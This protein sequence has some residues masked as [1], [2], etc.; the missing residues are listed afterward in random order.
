MNS[1]VFGETMENVRHDSDIKLVTTEKKKQFGIRTKLSYY[2]VFQRKF[3]GYK[4]EKNS[5]THENTHE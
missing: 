2:K 4:N 1:A 5:N 3:V